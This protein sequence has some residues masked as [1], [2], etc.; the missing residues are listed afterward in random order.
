ME[1]SAKEL[2]EILEGRIEGNP[3]VTVSAPSRIEEGKPGTISF[4][5]HPKYEEYAYTTKASILLVSNEFEPQQT[6]NA[7]LLRVSD[8]YGAMQKLLA[9]FEFKPEVQAFKHQTAIISEKATLGDN[10]SIAAHVVIEEGAEIGEN[11]ILHAA[12]FIGRNVKLGANCIVHSGARIMRESKIG[13]F[14]TI[15]PNAVVGSD[16]FGFAPNEKGEF[17]KIPQIG[18]V[19]LEDHVDV[20]ANSVIDRASIG[21]TILRRGVK[22]DNL[23]QIG[24]NVEIGENTA[25]AG[26]AGVAGST[27]IGKN[28][29]IGGQVGFAGHITIADGTMFAAKAGVNSDVKEPNQKL[30]GSPAVDYT[31]FWRTF[32]VYRTLPEMSRTVRRLEK[33]IAAMKNHLD[34]G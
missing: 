17:T 31:K 23:V 26:Q 30:C 3:E 18:N 6:V 20:G 12:S 22:I 5:G 14:C 32:A 9:H 13:D 10:V 34:K 24:H 16:G 2:S 28:C 1:I 4:L 25:L 33:E 21:S 11:C 7:T 19:I 8:V 27:K 29:L 15:H